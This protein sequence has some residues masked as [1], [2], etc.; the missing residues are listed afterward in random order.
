[1]VGRLAFPVPGLGASGFLMVCRVHVPYGLSVCVALCM[2]LAVRWPC[3]GLAL[4]GPASLAY[5]AL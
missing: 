3:A 5:G 1:M 2:V 4:A